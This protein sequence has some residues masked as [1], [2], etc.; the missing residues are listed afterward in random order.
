[1]SWVLVPCLVQLRTEFNRIGPGRDRSSDGSVADA[2]HVAGGNSD[3]IPDEE[4][5]A[6]RDHDADSK[7]EV[8]A[9]DV[10]DSGPW[11]DGFSMERAVQHL[12]A[13]CRSG[14]E[15]RLTYVIYERR[16][17]SASRGWVQRA[18]TGANPHDKHAHFSASYE[19]ARE[20][21]TA[22]WHLEELV[23][24]TDAEIEKIATRVEQ[25]VWNH[26]EPN[27]YDNGAT[28]R[29]MGG[30]LRMMEYRDD[31]RALATNVT[32]L[33]QQVIPAL[34]RIEAHLAAAEGRDLVDE[35]AIVAGV[36]AGLPAEAI[37]AAIPAGIAAEVVDELHR[38]TAPA[39]PP[40]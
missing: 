14:A 12:L 8:H 28:E 9:L 1:V 6:L 33:D 17:W 5:A 10:D 25:K 22:S 27:P 29:R 36:L 31:Q 18:Y 35:P 23:A 39:A 20:A 40:A 26:T 13:R 4:A 11:P 7:N 37:A 30:D 24:V 19:T 32:R 3:H 16:I 38:R 2:A 15:R 34:A 21:S